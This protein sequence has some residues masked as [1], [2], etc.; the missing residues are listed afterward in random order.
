LRGWLGRGLHLA[1]PQPRPT[2]ADAAR[3]PTAQRHQR[4]QC[5][6][7]G[8]PHCWLP[9]APQALGQKQSPSGKSE[10]HVPGTF[11]PLIDIEQPEHRGC[12]HQPRGC[13][14][15]QNEREQTKRRPDIS[16]WTVRFA[17]AT[18]TMAATAT[19]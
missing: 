10:I 13:G 18:S 15:Q 9:N 14:K 8:A 3:R 7:N 6:G 5:N 2:I 1:A 19:A 12:R 17:F 4:R 16:A 11:E